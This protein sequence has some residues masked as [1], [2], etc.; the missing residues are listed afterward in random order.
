LKDGESSG[1]T[2]FNISSAVDLSVAFTSQSNL[3]FPNL[4]LITG[5]FTFTLN[6]ATMADFPV[7]TSVG[8][9]LVISD[10]AFLVSFQA[11]ALKNISGAVFI[12]NAGLILI[13]SPLYQV[14]CEGG[15]GSKFSDVQGC[16][17]IG[18]DRSITTSA[19]T[20]VASSLLTYTSGYLSI[21]GN[22]VLATINLSSL[23]IVWGTLYIQQNP[24][25]TF[26]NLPKL[27]YIA[28]A[29]HICANNAAF[30]IPGPPNIPTSGLTTGY[31]GSRSCQYDSGSGSCNPS[32][33]WQA[34]P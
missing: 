32:Q 18:A 6:L 9:D 28:G 21:S 11:A 7:L 23:S 3:A 2:L 30:R 27:T 24:A 16:N 5:D 25:L 34:C 19:A 22:D 10:N 14:V 4:E 20:T 1:L 31:R 33:Y 26:F 8:G 12:N 13:L 17:R 15:S 29:L